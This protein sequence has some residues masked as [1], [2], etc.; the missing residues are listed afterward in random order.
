MDSLNVQFNVTVL[1]VPDFIT[2]EDFPGWLQHE[3]RALQDMAADNSLIIM[4]LF[5][6]KRI[7]DVLTRKRLDILLQ[8][9]TDKYPHIFRAEMVVIEDDLDIDEIEWIQSDAEKELA[10]LLETVEKFQEQKIAR[11]KLH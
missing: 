2:P 5:L 8:E 3:A 10:E 9:I 4:R 7:K 6:A 1:T 11:G